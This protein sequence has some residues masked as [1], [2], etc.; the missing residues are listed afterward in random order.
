M[1]IPNNFIESKNPIQT[2]R[3]LILELITIDLKI[4][5]SNI[6]AQHSSIASIVA[7]LLSLYKRAN[8]PNPTPFS[9]TF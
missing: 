3:L 4:E 5:P 7:D 8:S 9:K 6:Y 2:V 1:Y